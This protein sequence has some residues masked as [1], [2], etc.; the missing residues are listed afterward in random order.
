MSNS[1]A[2]NIKILAVEDDSGDYGLIRVYLRMAGYVPNIVPDPLTWVTT[3]AHAEQQIMLDRPDIILLDLNL[4]D[5]FGISTVK[6]MRT[7]LPTVPIIVLSGNNDNDIALAA[8]EEGAQDFVIKGQYEHNALGKAISHALIRAKLEAKLIESEFRWKFAIEGS[9]DGL[10]D[11]DV[12]QNTVFYSLRWKQMLDYTDDEI[13]NGLDEWSLR[14]HPDDKADTIATVQAYLAGKTSCYLSEHRV[15]C[16]QGDYKWILDRGMVVARDADGKPLRLIG[17]HTDITE[18]KRM[19]DQVRQLAFY[20]TLTHLP[21]RRLLNDRLS[22]AMSVGKRSGGYGALIFLDLDNFKPIND[23]HGHVAGDLLLIEAADR[24]RACVREMDTVAR[25]G[26]DEFVVVLSELDTDDKASAIEASRVA[27][28][29]LARLS[30]PYQLTV[31]HEGQPDL[32]IEHHCTAS[33]GLVL[34][35]GQQV[36]QNDIIVSADAAM[37]QAKNAGRNTIRFYEAD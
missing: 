14:I 18:H 34:F 30:E 15:L 3:L 16:K 4:P 11:W 7:L 35:L 6:R 23:T 32:H 21:N 2:S 33:I 1:P 8:L 17:T 28:K 10:W 22:Q 37:Y 25:F 19:E 24:L 26:G 12:A 31:R 27:E 9:G 36:S 13:G 5:S 20:D 29:I